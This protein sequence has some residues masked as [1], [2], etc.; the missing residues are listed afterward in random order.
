[1]G[2]QPGVAGL[3]LS[4]FLAKGED[5]N[6]GPHALTIKRAVDYIIKSQQEDNGYIGNSMYNHGFAT[7][8]LA[9]AYGMVNDDRIAP[10]LK[11]AVD[12]ILSAQKRNP[13]KA[14]RYTP[15]S[16]DADTTVTGCQ[17]V[18]LYA[19]RNAGIAVPEAAFKNAQRYLT[20]CR[21]SNGAYGYVTKT[22]PKV[23]LT[24][25][26]SLTLSLMKERDSA[27]YRSSLNYLKS[28]INYR[29]THYPFYFEYYMS[30]ALF[31][32]DEKLWKQWNA[33]NIRVLSVS[34]NREGFWSDNKGSAY[35]TSCALLSLALNYR[36]LPVY[37]R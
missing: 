5:A 37:E 18:A 1:M 19:A 4:A 34:Q 27:G 26:G 23:T 29:E 17:I 13:L 20:S 33:D 6:H 10:A 36:Y 3:C 2:T 21:N 22:A 14:W 35:A 16:T 9:E 25:I 24:A 28:N 32:S 15:D 31:H 30:Q 7:L 11:K 8:G 12:L